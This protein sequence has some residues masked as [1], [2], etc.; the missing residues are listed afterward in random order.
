MVRS[1]K[2]SNKK[3]PPKLA[4]SLS[5]INRYCWSGMIFIPIALTVSFSVVVLP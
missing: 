5:V 4:A 3:K 1:W 2:L